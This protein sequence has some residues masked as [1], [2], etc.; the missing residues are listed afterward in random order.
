MR[1]WTQLADLAGF[2]AFYTF[3][4]FYQLLLLAKSRK[5]AKKKFVETLMDRR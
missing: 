3:I 1:I 4:N 2:K 5:S